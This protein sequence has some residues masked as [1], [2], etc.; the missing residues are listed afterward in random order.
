MPVRR[1]RKIVLKRRPRGEPQPSDFELLEEP[2]PEP[3]EGRVLIETIWLSVDP[4]V[5][6]RLND[7]PSYTAP[8]GIGEPVHGEC[9]G[10]IL[11]SRVPGLDPGMFVIGMGG[12]QSHFIADPSGLRR[13]DPREAPLS[14][15]LGVLGMPGLTAYA[16]LFDIADPRS[17]ETVVVPA[18]TGAVGTVAGQLAREV[19]A[20][21]VGIAGGAE[22][23]RFAVEEL[24]F[25]SCIDR[26][27]DGF[28]ERLQQACPDGV[29]VYLELVG[30]AVLWAVLPLMNLHGRIPVVGGI[31]W[32]NLPGLPQGPDRT[33]MLMRQILVRRL[34]MQGMIV[35]D[36]ARLEA[37]FHRHVG[38]LLREGRIR[39]REQ[40]Y[41]GLEAAPRALID[42]LSGRTFGKVLV[43]VSPQHEAS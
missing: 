10:R 16:A 7:A 22:K 11:K 42:L 13:L 40:V 35:W 29:D 3:P 36:H 9:V 30:G 24:G 23:C 38:A 33:P 6:G 2:L 25:D 34:R 26:H 4:Y 41:E 5:R 39:Y 17:G 18:A 12:W 14:A 31:A 37:D 27:Q 19:G 28:E 1:M 43:A 21:V 8:V 32:Y 20:R 15:W